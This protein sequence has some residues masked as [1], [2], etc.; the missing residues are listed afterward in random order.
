MDGAG[1]RKYYSNEIESLLNLYQQFSI[2]I[3]ACDTKVN[4]MQENK[5]TSPKGKDENKVSRASSSNAEDGR[6]VE[7]LIRAYFKKVLPSELDV[8]TGFILRPAVKCGINDKSRKDCTDKHST[9]L[10]ILIYDKAHYPTFMRFENNVIVP[11]EC[12]IAIISVKKTLKK[13]DLQRE[14]RCLSH[15]AKLCRSSSEIVEGC[16]VKKRLR[17]D[18]AYSVRGP[19]L[20]IVA[21]D[22]T[23]AKPE[24]VFNAI[25]EA[26][27]DVAPLY[28]DETVGYV[29]SLHKWSI[30]KRR[31]S[32]PLTKVAEYVFINNASR[33]DGSF[34]IGFQLILTGILS[35]Y[36][37]PSR[38]SIK[39]PGFTAF[40]PGLKHDGELGSID[41]KGLR[42]EDS[43]YPDEEYMRLYKLI[44]TKKTK[45]K[46]NKED[47]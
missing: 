23:I 43:L 8:A 5:I 6:Y 28:F 36:Y 42:K 21:P 9:Q 27:Q 47:S 40:E 16:I 45:K 37:D 24:T 18:K 12:V 38:L 13:S 3:P 1:I 25:T 10:D 7:S 31:P 15:A 35:V 46:K 30:F 44:H 2:L 29:G 17:K 14:I 39:R 33:E 32:M 11:P 4:G 34:H 22:T 19:F 20:A 41:V 26:Y